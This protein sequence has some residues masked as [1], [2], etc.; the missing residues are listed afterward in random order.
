MISN[1]DR[2][3]LFQW[4]SQNA[5]SLSNW[6][7]NEIANRARKELK[8][9][10]ADSTVKRTIED[11]GIPIKIKR[12][13][14]MPPIAQLFARLDKIEKAYMDLC[15]KVGVEPMDLS[16]EPDDTTTN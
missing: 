9:D 15:E 10:C 12:M 14:Q 1:G 4:L 8:I 11:G 6:S 5:V 7:L 3:K 16:V 2:F 13:S